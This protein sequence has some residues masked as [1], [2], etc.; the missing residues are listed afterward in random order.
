MTGRELFKRLA[1]LI[2]VAS[3]ALRL[4]PR[5]LVA[6]C[7]WMFAFFPGK[8]GIGIRYLL[9]QRLCSSCGRNVLFGVGVTVQHWDR[10]SIGD[11]VTIHQ[12]CYLDANG[13]I[14][15]GD[16][17]SIAHATSLVAFEHSWD[18]LDKPIKYNP[19]VLGPITIQS[20]V[21]IGCGV[22]VLSG[23]TI[24]TRTVIAAGAVVTR[25]EYGQGVYGGVP[26]RRL[27]SLERATD[28]Q[29]HIPPPVHSEPIHAA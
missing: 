5:R 3:F 12:Y 9:A 8:M 25:G 27:K 22:R 7:W 11:N 18:D 21:W 15:I 26:A 4:L 6:S 20:D 24:G 19:L 13:G 16:Q 23:A 17:V 10:L 14:L 29:E 1:P 28:P 2:N